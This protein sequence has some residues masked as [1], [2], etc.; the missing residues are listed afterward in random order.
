MYAKEFL[1]LRVADDF[2]Y[3][4]CV[5]WIKLLDV[6][7]NMFAVTSKLNKENKNLC[8]YIF[9]FIIWYFE[10]TQYKNYLNNKKNKK[11]LISKIII[12]GE[13]IQIENV[14]RE[15]VSKRSCYK[16]FLIRENK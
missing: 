11:S 13:V 14:C 1:K 6:F 15:K 16:C 8:I 3:I 7:Y 5:Y 2:K 12:T 9:I 10:N 4:L